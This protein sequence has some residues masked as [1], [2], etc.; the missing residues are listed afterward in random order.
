MTR[1]AY[2]AHDALTHTAARRVTHS[3]TRNHQHI[4]R[5]GWLAPLYYWLTR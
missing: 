4:V 5:T 1:S 2:S 3:A